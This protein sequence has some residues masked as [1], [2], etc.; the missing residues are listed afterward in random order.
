MSAPRRIDVTGEGCVEWS[1]GGVET[2]SYFAPIGSYVRADVADEMTDALQRIV[3]ASENVTESN[4][5]DAPTRF[6]RVIY[7]VA[8]RAIAKAEGN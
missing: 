7:R 3:D 8:S 5:D 2:R 6:A 4:D 1:E